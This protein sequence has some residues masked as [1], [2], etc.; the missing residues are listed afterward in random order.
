VPGYASTKLL[1]GSTNIS[2]VVYTQFLLLVSLVFAAGGIFSPDNLHVLANK[3]KRELVYALGLVIL[4]YIFLTL[5]YG[6]WRILATV[7]LHSVKWLLNLTGTICNSSST[8]TLLLDKFG[9]NIAQYCS[10]IE[11]IGIYLRGLYSL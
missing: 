11:S 9:I 3:Y 7:V 5:V 4:F 1:S 6:L 8:R 10:G 2:L